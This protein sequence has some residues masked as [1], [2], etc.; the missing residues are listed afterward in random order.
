MSSRPT[1]CLVGDVLIDVTLRTTSSDTK[2]RFGGIIHCARALWALNIPY[3]VGYFAPDYLDDQIVDYLRHHNCTNIIKLGTTIGT[4]NVI[5]IE[6]AKEIGDQGYELL[7]RDTSRIIYDTDKILQIASNNY[8][9]YLIIAG[10]Y[11][12][13][14]VVNKLP[15]RKH[16]DVA[17]NVW[18]LDDLKQLNKLQTVFISTSSKIFKNSFNESFMDFINQFE[19]IAETVVLKENRGGSR[20][21][22]FSDERFYEVPAQPRTIVHSVGVGDVFDAVYVTHLSLGIKEKGILSSWIAAEYAVT[23]FPDDF[24]TGVSRVMKSNIHEL[25]PMPGVSLPWEQRKMINIYIAAPDFTHVNTERIEAMDAAL[26]Y[27][28][29]TPRRPIK[30]N[31]QMEE[32][33]SKFKKQELVAKDMQMLDECSLLVGILL[34]NDPGT[35]IEIGYAKAIGMPTLVYDPY[36]LASNCMLTELPDLLSS[37]MDEILTEV[38]IRSANLG[39]HG[40]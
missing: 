14:L 31:G 23:T 34:Y 6:E 12:L 15:A 40:K 5:L 26:R 21:Y 2:L 38:F 24:K 7:L 25:L 8:S 1:I 33:A 22:N 30:E 20:V 17:N 18:L 13:G 36:N 10:N 19:S 39:K 37:D 3:D 29:F 32:N 9:D 11:D 35:L 28:N 16:I 27:H 4:P